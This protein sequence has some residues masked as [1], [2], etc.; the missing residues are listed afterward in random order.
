MKTPVV[1]AF[2]TEKFCL[3]SVQQIINSIDE[4]CKYG[5][6]GKHLAL[7]IRQLDSTIIFMD[8]C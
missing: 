6:P 1:L 3:V 8:A 2:I 7:L 5:T 4:I